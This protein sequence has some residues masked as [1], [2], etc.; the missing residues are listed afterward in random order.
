MVLSTTGLGVGSGWGVFS[1]GTF[2][3]LEAAS[4]LLGVEVF[5][6]LGAIVEGEGK[7]SGREVKTK[8]NCR[9]REGKVLRV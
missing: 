5:L 7:G 3:L 6:V 2:R 8:G 1:N 4:R 9:E